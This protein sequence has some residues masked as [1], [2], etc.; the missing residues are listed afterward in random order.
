[1]A[2]ILLLHGPNLN[3]LGSRE[4]SIYG[5]C[6][7]D[8]IN[9]SVEQVLSNRSH[10]LICFQSNHE[11]EL[12][13]QI[14]QAQRQSVAFIIINPAAYTHTSIAMRDALLAVEIPFIE[15]HLSDPLQR[16]SF[17]HTSYFSDI[18]TKVFSGHGAESYTLAAE[19]AIEYL[20]Q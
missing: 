1:M 10:Q 14:Q 8:S 4:T 11:G 15:V 3:L 18:A 2:T 13:D 7:M 16:E 17:R 5:Q 12:V 20:G 19:A 9:Q 6:S